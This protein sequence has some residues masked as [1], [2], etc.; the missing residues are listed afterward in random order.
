MKIRNREYNRL[1]PE[2]ISHVLS[3]AAAPTSVRQILLDT[4]L[5]QE[6]PAY[7]KIK[8]REYNVAHVLSLAAAPTSVR[9]ILLDTR[10]LQEAPALE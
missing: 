3:L 4:R 10:L 1:T 2:N 9:Q 7:I 5:L 8:N 6:A